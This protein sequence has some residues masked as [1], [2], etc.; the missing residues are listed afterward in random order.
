MN[1]QEC[2]Q[3]RRPTPAHRWMADPC[4][5]PLSCAASDGGVEIEVEVEESARQVCGEQSGLEEY[6]AMI[7]VIQGGSDDEEDYRR[8]GEHDSESSSV[9]EGRWQCVSHRPGRTP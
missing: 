9:S 5:A 8:Y 2:S 4:A 6:F 1:V 3:P 7:R